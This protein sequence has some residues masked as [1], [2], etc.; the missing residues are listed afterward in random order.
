M[1]Q[2]Q[3]LAARLAALILLSLPVLAQGPL[4]RERWA[5]L[6]L[7]L[8]RERVVE[9]CRGRDDD[10]V[11]KAASLLVTVDDSI[12]FRP[13]SEALAHLRGV[14]CDEAFF[15]RS[16]IGAFVL[17][18]VVDPDAQK[19]ECHALNLTVLLPYV[20]PMPA[21]VRFTVEVFDSKWTR[22]H[23]MDFGAGVPQEDLR[24]GQVSVSVPCGELEDG[25]YHAR[26]TIVLDGKGPRE[27]DPVCSHVFHVLRGYQQRAESVQRRYR[28]AAAGLDP[29]PS[30]LL[31]GIVTEM[32]RAYAGEAFDGSS[33]AVAD[34][35][36]AERALDNLKAEE[37]V[38]ASLKHV[39][40]TALP[41]TGSDVLPAVLRWPDAD[42]STTDRKPLILVLAAMPAFD[43]RGRRPVWPEVRSAR[44]SYRKNGD[45][46]LGTQYPFAWV[47]SPG[48]TIAYAKELPA[49]I[50]AAHELLP[51]DGTT[52]LVAELEAAVAVCYAP[53]VLALAR[54]VVLVGAGA[55][56]Q[57]Q[58]QSYADVPMLGIPLSGHG[59]S[60]G[61][62]FTAGLADKLRAAGSSSGYQL[63]PQRPR[64]WVGGAACARGEIAKFVRAIATAK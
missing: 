35:E 38:L 27:Q 63:L 16:T 56:S 29:L 41:T 53:A 48:G 47:Q 11:E 54:G 60:S 25:A 34:L 8:L 15:V 9:E 55:L 20:I 12:P 7:Q 57:Q 6:H 61:L 45:F 17:P 36:R 24:L 43:T 18:E 59:S 14:A 58:L 13:A 21:D 52:I 3:L 19:V 37:P 42:Q 40:P 22:V 44:W 4:Y 62:E 5:D 39:L 10:T 1:G 32:N 50:A 51:T 64:P 26:L 30:A 46:G 28:E 31:R 23:D 49:A 33:D 2:S